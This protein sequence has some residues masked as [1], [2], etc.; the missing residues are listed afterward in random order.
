MKTG[1]GGWKTIYLHFLWPFT[2]PN[3]YKIIA[4][5]GRLSTPL[6]LFRLSNC[7]MYKSTLKFILNPVQVY[8]NIRPILRLP[9]LI[10]LN[11]RTFTISVISVLSKLWSIWLKLIV[12]NRN[13]QFWCYEKTLATFTFLVI[14]K[15]LEIWSKYTELSN[16][17]KSARSLVR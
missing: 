6:P 17:I 4:L 1:G 5:S 15:Q 12:E 10:L 2:S 7:F 16:F 14:F 3:C 8:L 9:W 11:A 13:F